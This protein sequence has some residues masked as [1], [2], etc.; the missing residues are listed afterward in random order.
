MNAWPRFDWHQIF[1][2]GAA[3]LLDATSFAG[4]R[5]ASYY[6]NQR[7]ELQPQREVASAKRSDADRNAAKHLFIEAFVLAVGCWQITFTGCVFMY[8]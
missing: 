8:R 6:L 5:G 4:I 2:V 3:R 1:S 7:L